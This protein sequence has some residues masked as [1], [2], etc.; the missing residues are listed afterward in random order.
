M[1]HSFLIRMLLLFRLFTWSRSQ[2][3]LGVELSNN[4]LR[5]KVLYES[6]GAE[7][8]RTEQKITH[9]TFSDCVYFEIKI[10][11][12]AESGNLY[13]GLTSAS[14]NLHNSVEGGEGVGGTYWYS[15]DGSIFKNGRTPFGPSFG[16][17]DVIGCG[18]ERKP[19]DSDGSKFRLFYTFNGQNLGTTADIPEFHIPEGFCPSV[20]FIGKG[21]EVE[22][23][24]SDLEGYPFKFDLRSHYMNNALSHYNKSSNIKI[25][26]RDMRAEIKKKTRPGGMVMANAK[27]KPTE[28]KVDYFEVKIFRQYIDQNEQNTGM[29][30]FGGAMKIGLK[31]KKFSEDLEVY[32]D[33]E[34]DLRRAPRKATI[35]TE[36]YWYTFDGKKFE[37]KIEDSKYVGDSPHEPYGVT[38]GEGAIVGCGLTHDR[39]IFFTVNGESQGLAFSATPEGFKDGLYPCIDLHS[40]WGIEANFGKERFAFDPDKNCRNELYTLL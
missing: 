32:I 3:P 26:N 30:L 39:K 40:S 12:V 9:E 21:W 8:I 34:E 5:A 16:L 2:K 13:I 36:R 24:F 22:G 28:S 29:E 19:S 31:T 27:L 38:Y 17:N 10:L 37:S 33:A 20:Y 11:S 18:I 35:Q 25:L 4:N 15:N 7:I 6:S 1:L 14:Q 23:N